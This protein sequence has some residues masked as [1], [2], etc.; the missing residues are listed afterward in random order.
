M[1]SD[2][3]VLIWSVDWSDYTIP[4]IANCF[5][6]FVNRQSWDEAGWQLK[7]FF[8]ACMVMLS[9]C[10][11]AL[12]WPGLSLWLDNHDSERCAMKLH[13]LVVLL[14]LIRLLEGQFELPDPFQVYPILAWFW[15]Y[16]TQWMIPQKMKLYLQRTVLCHFYQWCQG[17]MYLQQGRL[18][19]M[20]SR[21]FNPHVGSL[22]ARF[23]ANK[24]SSVL[25]DSA[26]AGS[27]KLLLVMNIQISHSE[28]SVAFLLPSNV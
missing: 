13:I 27:I 21:R 16:K 14:D 4:S 20:R 6:Q 1:W 2:C 9:A 11:P 7:I 22:K 10:R 8:E 23:R 15:C 5:C 12:I 28:H 17:E 3:R 19:R 18:A 24:A 25:K 26:R